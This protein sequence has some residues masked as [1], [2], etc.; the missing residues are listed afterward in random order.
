MVIGHGFVLQVEPIYWSIM[1]IRF[2]ILCSILV[3]QLCK[4]PWNRWT[5]IDQMK[6]MWIYVEFVNMPWSLW[7]GVLPK[8]IMHCKS[9]CWG[10]HTLSKYAECNDV[11]RIRTVCP[12]VGLLTARSA[13]APTK[14]EIDSFICYA[15]DS[16]PRKHRHHQMT[17]VIRAML[18]RN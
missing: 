9:W 11:I 15:F 12:I 8:W 6:C 4:I 14:I 5:K 17:T 2:I 1:S 3:E 16:T 10:Q 13:P 18:I 7:P